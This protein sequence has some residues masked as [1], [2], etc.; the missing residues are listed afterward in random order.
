MNDPLTRRVT[1]YCKRYGMLPANGAVLCAVSGGRDSMCLLHLLRALSQREDFR[2]EA[3]HFNHR[4]RPAAGRDEA[5]VR[6]T[7]ARWG[8]PLTLGGGDVAA[9]AKEAGKGLEDAGRTLR[10]AFLEKT[11]AERGC[12]RIATAHHREDNAETVLLHLLRGSGLR[13]LGGIPP[14]R[15]SIIRPLLEVSREEIDAYVSRH[16]LPYVEDETNAHPAYLRNRVRHELLPLLEE[17]SPGAA[18]RIAHTAALL[19]EDGAYLD[20]A[21]E[22]LLP[23]GEEDGSTLPPPLLQAPPPLA[24]RLVRLAAKRLG[25]SLTAAQTETLL[26]LES[27][28]YQSLP[29][30]L[31]ARRDKAGLHLERAAAPPPPMVLRPGVQRWGQWEISLEEAVYAGASNN[32]AALRKETL[33]GPLTAAAWD[34][35][36]RLAVEN[37]SRSIKRLLLD[38]GIPPA[39]QFQTPVLYREG[40]PVAALGAVDLALRPQPGELSV[41]IQFHP[42]K[43]IQEENGS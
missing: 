38:Q 43:N 11:A 1:A 37:G 41:I 14:V 36:G 17:L 21:A 8:I 15:G 7:C 30:G 24:R 34:G 29:G 32:T 22:A 26:S 4:L 40:R 12:G 25:G 18:G 5:F 35:T 28:K 13:G 10:Y 9:Y 23:P 27:G 16:A 3:A 6:E 39:R 31:A 33:T 19:R 42:T 20:Q 2:L